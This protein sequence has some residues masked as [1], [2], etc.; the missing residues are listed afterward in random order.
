M[1][2]SNDSIYIKSVCFQKITQKTF[3]KINLS[4]LKFFI[5]S[6]SGMIDTPGNI[7]FFISDKAFYMNKADYH[8]DF[9]NEILSKTKDK[10]WKKINLYFCDD[11]IIN[12]IISDSF[13]ATLYAKN[14]RDFWFETAIEIYKDGFKNIV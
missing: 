7:Y 6:R 3:Q 13:T 1:E 14:I 8:D 11:L 10:K 4:D 12:P 5:I 9:I 2:F